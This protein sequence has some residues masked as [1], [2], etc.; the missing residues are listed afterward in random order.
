MIARLTKACTLD[1]FQGDAEQTLD[2]FVTEE[3]LIRSLTPIVQHAS[4]N[5][6][7]AYQCNSQIGMNSWK[8]IFSAGSKVL[9]RCK[10][11][12]S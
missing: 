6:H 1:A 12:S 2:S 10:L 11:L 9:R 4:I 8:V 7:L 5:N 3:L